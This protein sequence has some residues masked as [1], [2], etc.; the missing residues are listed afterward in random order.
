MNG[1]SKFSIQIQTPKEDKAPVNL[2]AFPSISMFNDWGFLQ[3]LK[4][5]LISNQDNVTFLL[6]GNAWEFRPQL[7]Q[8]DAK[9]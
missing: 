7:A 6:C 5:I 9:F 3:I 4:K 8:S 1:S 2:F